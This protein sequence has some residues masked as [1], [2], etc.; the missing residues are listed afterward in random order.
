M[1]KYSG[2]R[3]LLSTFP[4]KNPLYQALLDPPPPQ[5]PYHKHGH[6]LARLELIDALVDFVYA[7]WVKDYSRQ[8]CSRSM[9]SS[10]EAYLVHCKRKWQV[11]E[12][13]DEREKALLALMWVSSALRSYALTSWSL[14]NI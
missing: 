4:K 5:S 2:D 7:I 10:T 11:E 8:K 3:R 1:L 9:W 14:S 12:G 6:L 13:S